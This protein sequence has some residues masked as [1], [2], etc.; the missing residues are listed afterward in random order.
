MDAG[1][2]RG[3][4]SI[5]KAIAAHYKDGGDLDTGSAYS[6]LLFP[7]GNQKAVNR[8]LQEA[9]VDA[10]DRA[11]AEKWVRTQPGA[12][13]H[14]IRVLLGLDD[15][16]KSESSDS[17]GNSD[18][19]ESAGSDSESDVPP[20]RSSKRKAGKASSGKSTPVVKR[21]R[22]SLQ[23]IEAKDVKEEEGVKVE[24]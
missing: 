20:A 14:Q 22:T 19:I 10:A 1:S 21:R 7:F 3:P 8:H 15:V 11:I 18:G 5:C 2:C 6:A 23:P 17:G 9:H 4:D 13:Q 16:I 24:E 12:K